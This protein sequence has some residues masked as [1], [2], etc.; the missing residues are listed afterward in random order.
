V[1]AGQGHVALAIGGGLWAIV[2]PLLLGVGLGW[3][4][5]GA[6]QAVVIDPSAKR[7]A[8]IVRVCPPRDDR[9]AGGCEPSSA[10]ERAQWGL[11]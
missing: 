5:L 10:I 4:V 9:V 8:Q 6:L 1:R 7:S 11:R 3:I 2:F